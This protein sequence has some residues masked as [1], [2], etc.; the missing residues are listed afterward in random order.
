MHHRSFYLIFFWIFLPVIFLTVPLLAEE[1]NL[2]LWAMAEKQLYLDYPSSSSPKEALPV[3]TPFRAGIVDTEL[4]GGSHLTIYG[5]KVIGIKYTYK[6]YLNA[7]DKEPTSS[8]EVD[9]KLQAKVK[10]RIGDRIFVDF[11]FSS[12]RRHTR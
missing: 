12:R 2:N 4:P 1:T 9:Q 3:L 8:T 5:R 10:G 11:F 7:P 6:E